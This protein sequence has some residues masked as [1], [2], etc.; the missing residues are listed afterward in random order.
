VTDHIL[1][2]RYEGNLREDRARKLNSGIGWQAKTCRR[3]VW[4]A[5]QNIWKQL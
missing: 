4:C 5:R 1:K 2:D 3:K